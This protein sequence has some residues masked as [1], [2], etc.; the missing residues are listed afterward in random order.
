MCVGDGFKILSR[1]GRLV[2]LRGFDDGANLI[3]EVEVV[4]A[5]TAWEDTDGT[6]YILIFNEALD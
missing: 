1:T 2:N 4:T 6:V 3:K 5:A